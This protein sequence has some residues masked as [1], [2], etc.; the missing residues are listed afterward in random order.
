M[1][2]QLAK[3]AFWCGEPDAI[4][5][6]KTHGLIMPD[7]WIGI[8]YADS[9]SQAKSKFAKDNYMEFTQVRA[10]RAKSH[11]LYHFEGKEM[12]L[13]RIEE[14]IKLREWRKL[15]SEAVAASPDMQVLIYSHQ[16]EC[17]WRS[18][19]C[20]YTTKKEEAGVYTMKQAWANVAHCGLE[21]GIEI[22]PLHLGV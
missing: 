8:E 13:N 15:N 12:T 21:K 7:E 5:R 3:K 4:F 19:A 9:P 22:R 2:Y 18:N 14:K 11:D 20:G 6:Q 16:W 10:I 1:K 17:Y